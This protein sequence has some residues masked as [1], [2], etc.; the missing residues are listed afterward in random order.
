MSDVLA[1]RGR[2]CDSWREQATAESPGGL[3]ATA[4]ANQHAVPALRPSSVI[5]NCV[6]VARVRRGFLLCLLF[7]P[8]EAASHS[9]RVT[10]K[11]LDVSDGPRPRLAPS[12][13]QNTTRLKALAAN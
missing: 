9:T 13:Y 5:V 3:D 7:S 6:C 2:A 8:V 4:P 1:V 12:L 11:S 10:V